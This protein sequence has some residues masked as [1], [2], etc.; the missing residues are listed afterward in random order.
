MS[1]VATFEGTPGQEPRRAVDDVFD[2]PIRRDELRKKPNRALEVLWL[3]VGIAAIGGFVY[4]GAVLLGSTVLSPQAWAERYV[5]LIAEGDFADASELV[6]PQLDFTQLELL[7]FAVPSEGIQDVVVTPISETGPSAK[8][9]VAFTLDGAPQESEL[10]L[11]RRTSFFGLASEWRVSTALLGS[12]RLTSTGPEALNVGGVDV[13]VPGEA[14]FPAYPGVYP[15][16]LTSSDTF[17]ALADPL[18]AVVPANN[19]V[20][21]PVTVTATAA[22]AEGAQ[23]AVVAIIDECAASGDIAP[24]GCSFGAVLF[25]EYRNLT[26]RIT[27]YPELEISED[28]TRFHSTSKGRAYAKFEQENFAGRGWV[29]ASYVDKFAVTGTLTVVDGVIIAAFDDGAGGTVG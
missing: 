18:S 17:F 26:W 1:D 13:A 20:E 3:V 23:A 12:V 5:T 29:D 24:I 15:V 11:W 19:T 6:D 9:H 7:D 22:Y 25:D 8:V 27:D 21:V 28:G 10:S 4:G 14:I 2:A 16:E